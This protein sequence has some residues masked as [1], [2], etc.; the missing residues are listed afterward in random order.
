M[1]PN[2]E[3]AAKVNRTRR[4]GY[5]CRECGTGFDAYNRGNGFCSTA[6]RKTFNNRRA[7]RG[8]EIYD[9]FMATRFEREKSAALG[10]WTVLCFVASEHRQDDLDKRGGRNSWR[11]PEE[12][13]AEKPS[14]KA[15]LLAKPHRVG[16]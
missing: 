6:C 12:I 3:P 10:L 7:T 2:L 13:L 15:E 14:L 16:R 8:A 11:P 1:T 5:V 9:L 4:R